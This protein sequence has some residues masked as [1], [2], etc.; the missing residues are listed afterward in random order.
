MVAHLDPVGVLRRHHVGEPQRQEAVDG[1]VQSRLLPAPE[2]AGRGH[3][4]GVTQTV[5]QRRDR[6]R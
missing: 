3:P 1:P 5:E 2:R 6:G 4:T